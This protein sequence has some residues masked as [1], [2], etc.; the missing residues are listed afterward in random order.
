MCIFYLTAIQK[1]SPYFGRICDIVVFDKTEDGILTP[2]LNPVVPYFSVTGCKSVQRANI[3]T[4][5]WL[6]TQYSVHVQ[7]QHE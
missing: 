7:V 3:T 2:A 5:V 4:C 1:Y 6:L